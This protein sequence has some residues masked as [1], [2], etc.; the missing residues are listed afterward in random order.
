[1]LAGLSLL[2]FTSSF[3]FATSLTATTPGYVSLGLGVG[4]VGFVNVGREEISDLVGVLSEFRHAM[5]IG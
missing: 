5:I 1:M 2:S 4:G 3:S